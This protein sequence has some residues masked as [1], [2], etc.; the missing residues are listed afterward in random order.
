[1][2]T[3]YVI[4][5]AN[6]YDGFNPPHGDNFYTSQELAQKDCDQLNKSQNSKRDYFDVW[7]L[8]LKTS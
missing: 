1:M 2:E 5:E 3:I 8:K 6:G 7:D 4:I